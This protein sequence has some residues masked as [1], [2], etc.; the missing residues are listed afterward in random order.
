MADF[1]LNIDNISEEFAVSLYR[2]LN[3]EVECVKDKL[4]YPHSVESIPLPAY[5]T[6]KLLLERF[7]QRIGFT[8]NLSTMS[9]CFVLYLFNIANEEVK[10]TEKDKNLTDTTAFHIGSNMLIH[11]MDD[12]CQYIATM[13]FSFILQVFQTF[14]IQNFTITKLAQ[15][16][17]RV[18]DETKTAAGRE[19]QAPLAHKLQPKLETHFTHK[20]GSDHWSKMVMFCVQVYKVRDDI[21]NWDAWE[22]LDICTTNVEGLGPGWVTLFNTEDFEG[23]IDIYQGLKSYPSQSTF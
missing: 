5:E 22:A 2:F 9:L 3:N 16:Y 12:L 1:N 17:G 8:E 23:T 21:N 7:W 6:G 11:R 18:I 13:S 15:I 10:A 19:D 14:D 4:E 20:F